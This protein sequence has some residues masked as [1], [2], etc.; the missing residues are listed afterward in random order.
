MD[1]EQK[2]GYLVENKVTIGSFVEWSVGKMR[3]ETP[4]PAGLRVRFLP[5]HSGGRYV[6]DELPEHLFPIGSCIRHDADHYG[7][8]LTIDDLGPRS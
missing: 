2:N 7:L 5:D 4:V 3:Y 6:L 1:S 8:T